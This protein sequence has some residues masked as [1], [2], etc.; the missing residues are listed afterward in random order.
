MA[1]EI[2]LASF[3]SR[4]CG[5]V[6]GDGGASWEKEFKGECGAC[7][8]ER[9][10]ERVTRADAEAAFDFAFPFPL[11]PEAVAVAVLPLPL[12]L[13]VE[14]EAVVVAVCSCR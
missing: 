14:E 1:A 5:G 8:A 10:C 3:G 7:D 2:S 12:V 11:D 13:V 6:E 4:S 9:D